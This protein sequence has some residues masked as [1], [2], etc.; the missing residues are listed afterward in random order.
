MNGS[1]RPARR[2]LRDLLAL[3]LLGLAVHLILPQIATLEHSLQVIQGMAWWAVGLAA[4]AQVLSYLGSG[5]LLQAIVA[6][7]G[8][9]LSVVRSTLITTAS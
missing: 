8:D 3:L 9:R 4:G 7:T 5:V 6:M 2:W 1:P